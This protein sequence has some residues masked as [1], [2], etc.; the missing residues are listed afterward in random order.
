MSLVLNNII[1]VICQIKFQLLNYFNF[2]WYM[3]TL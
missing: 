3:I 1:N 2:W